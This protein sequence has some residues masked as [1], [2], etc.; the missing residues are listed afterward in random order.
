MISQRCPACD[1][2]RIRRG[3]RPTRFWAKLIFRYNLLCDNCNW[4]FVGFALPGFIS[5]KQT[6]SSKEKRE[7]GKSA[8]GGTSTAATN[9]TGKN[10]EN[11]GAASPR[12]KVRKKVKIRV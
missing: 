12:P 7:R 3:Y 2:S 4:E 9:E 6:K 11:E 5:T 8:Q 1:S 10:S